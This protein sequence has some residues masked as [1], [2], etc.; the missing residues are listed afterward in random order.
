MNTVT[1]ETKVTIGILLLTLILLFV[2]VATFKGGNNSNT[3]KDLAKYIQT[4]LKF[5]P[6]QVKPVGR[7]QVTGTGTSTL[8]SSS[9]ISVTEFMD[10]ECPACAT[11]GEALV[12]QMLSK[13]GNR[14]VITRRIFPV[15]GD[16]AVE[17]AQMVLA[18]QNIS[19][20]AYQKLHA[21]VLE[22]Q[23]SWIPL[24]KNE[25]VTFFKNLTADLG[26]NYDLLISIGKNQYAKQIES[27][28]AAAAAL[29]IRAT[30]SFIINNNTRV[31]GAI[32]LDQL[33]PY[34]EAR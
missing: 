25:R 10:Y 17:V 15:H 1:T 26:L 27:D 8:A 32:P 23:N 7:P 21:K 29:G 22:T 12:Q 24:G 3:E 2:G 9:I 33:V 4:D 20:E 34:L 18:A 11:V 28:K 19:N 16:P 31:T 5:D 6:A 14:I 30:P 13:Y